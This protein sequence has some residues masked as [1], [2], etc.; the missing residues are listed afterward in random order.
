MKPILLIWMGGGIGSVLRYLMQVGI[1]KISNVSFPV[2]TLL[3]NILGCFAIGLLYGLSER[4][5]WMT[6][7]WRLFFVTG[8]CG[9]F[10]TF[11][12][13]SY[14]N[15]SLLRQG[16]YMYFVLYI[17][18]SIALGLLATFGGFQITK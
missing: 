16:D 6:I 8:L 2:G 3:V 1:A 12:G 13:F 17:F 15:L 11:S 4:Y 7:E 10:T 18:F 9:G 5:A 14:E